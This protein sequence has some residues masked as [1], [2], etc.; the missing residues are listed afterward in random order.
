MLTIKGGA[1]SGSLDSMGL[2]SSEQMYLGLL[3][4]ASSSVRIA[5][6]RAL[7]HTNSSTESFARDVLLVLK[8][9]LPLFHGETDSRIRNEFISWTKKLFLRLQGAI[10]R[11]LRYE[12]K[13]DGDTGRADDSSTSLTMGHLSQLQ[14]HLEFVSWYTSFLMGELQ[15]TASYQRH[16]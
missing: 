16:I 10:R 13:H 12:A 11:L 8:R 3:V 6:L 1:L 9:T 5:A 15:P 2:P 4:H 14:D 7:T